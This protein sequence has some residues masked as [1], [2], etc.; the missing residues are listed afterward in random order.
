MFFFF[1][2][3]DGFHG[4][5]YKYSSNGCEVFHYTNQFPQEEMFSQDSFV[6]LKRNNKCFF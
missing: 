3:I 4:I 1:S 5:V 6:S 2:I